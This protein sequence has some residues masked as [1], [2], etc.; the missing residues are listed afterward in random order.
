M[1]ERKRL[2]VIGGGAAGFFS[3]INI[4]EKHPHLEVTILE[5]S[6]EVLQKV[7][8]SGGGR[9]NVTNFCF[10]PRELA[11]NYPRGKKE[12]LGPFNKFGPGDTMSWFAE[13]G[14]NLVAE[15]D[16]RMFPESNTSQT[17]IDCFLESAQKANVNIQYGN[18]VTGIHQFEKGWEIYLKS[19][20]LKADYLVIASG[21]SRSIWD[22]LEKLSIDI[23][24]PVPSL[25]TFKIK[26]ERLSDLS[27]ISVPFVTCTIPQL[28]MKTD[29]PLLI[30]HRGVSG[31]GILKLSSFA[32]RELAEVGYKFDLK[33]NWVAD[34][35]DAILE[36][37]KKFNLTEPN[38]KVGEYGRFE[39]A[40]RL[41]QKL[42][43]HCEI[44]L[45]KKWCELGRKKSVRLAEALTASRFSV[46]GKNT[47]KEEFVT[48][49]GVDLK[50]IDFRKMSHK[51]YPTLF[52]A[53]EVLDIDAVTG[54]FNFQAAWTTSWLISEN[55][56]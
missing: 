44:P 34:S 25:F 47:F 40:K 24:F 17:I 49:G 37:L 39:L 48:A 10:V 55:K 4:A 28:K 6:T 7:K 46:N 45:D 15:D 35:V 41:W 12:L 18:Q 42:L 51:N 54:G 9:C 23:V 33:I 56:F 29:G 11:K 52:F 1:S 3:A 13:R 36:E 53:G 30:T 14:V 32:A 19:G 2:V 20:N 16:N 26:D 22:K 31:P 8:V 38:K 27:G 43:L 50:Q 5:K 21:S